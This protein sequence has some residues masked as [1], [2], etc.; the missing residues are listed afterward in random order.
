MKARVR[1]IIKVMQSI[2]PHYL[3][4]EWDNVG[5]QVGEK[6]WAVKNIWI[7]LDPL[8]E[9]VEAACKKGIDLLIT[10]HP[11]IFKPL[12]CIDLSTT[13]GSIINMAICN[14][15]AIFSAHTNL[16]KARGGINDILADMIGLNNL[17]VLNKPIETEKFKLV[18]Y[19]P[20]EHEKRVFEA[21]FESG[22]GRIGNYTCCTFRNHGKGTFK[23]GSGSKPFIGKI[24]EI[25]HTDE[26]RIEL[27]VKKDNLKQLI[28]NI[29]KHHPYETLAYDIYPLFE[30]GFVSETESSEGL[31]RIGETNGKVSLLSLAK[32]IK[33]KLGLKYIKIAGRPDLTI[34]KVAV[35]S[36]SGSSLME[37]FLASDAEVYISGDL[38]YHNA[39]TAEAAGRGL[40]DIGHFESEHIVV[41]N[42][43]E[44]LDKILTEAG[45]DV[46]IKACDMESDPFMI[47]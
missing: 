4:E 14:Q 17:T 25:F 46:G 16:D 5:L 12:K 6:D 24:G 13:A 30:P 27:V 26:S 28:D 35:C 8:E 15:M 33:E 32:N 43:T 38:G 3:T 10:H 41:K 2:A 29:R 47:L 40:I 9:V 44:K 39:R 34:D 22:E 19:V 7:A 20:L 31:G 36:G 21:F 1:D 18:I 23:P 37:D 11:M 42:L 45:F